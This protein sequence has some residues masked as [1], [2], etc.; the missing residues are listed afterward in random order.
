MY[1]EDTQQL[2]LGKYA[3]KDH[4]VILISK[5]DLNSR[6]VETA[7]ELRKR[8]I[9]TIAITSSKDTLLAKN[10]DIVLLGLFKM[11]VAELGNVMFSISVSYLLLTLYGLLL[12]EHYDDFVAIQ[13]NYLKSFY[14]DPF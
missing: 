14:N 9:S 7:K 10:S 5:T 11:G 1:T 6:I 3:D 2:L 12:S 4:V 13:E 8:H